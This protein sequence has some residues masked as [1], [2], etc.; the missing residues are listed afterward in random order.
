MIGAAQMRHAQLAHA[1]NWRI[2]MVACHAVVPLPQ[3]LGYL[4]SSTGYQDEL[5]YAAAMLYKVTGALRWAALCMRVCM[6]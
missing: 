3:V 4:Y 1:L 5:A 2:A 6:V